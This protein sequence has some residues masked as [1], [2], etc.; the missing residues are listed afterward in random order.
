MT[1]ARENI[2]TIP[3]PETGLYPGIDYEEYNLW[4]AVR[5][6]NLF[7]LEEG[8]L[9]HYRYTVD[10]P[11]EFDTEAYRVG[12]AGHVA[13]LEP[14][15]FEERYILKPATYTTAKGETKPFNAGA[16]ICK[17]V[18]KDLAATGKSILPQDEWDLA[19]A[20]GEACR[21]KESVKY[22]LD[23]GQTEVCVVWT[24]ERTGLKCKC[25][26]DLL[27]GVNIA[28]LKTTATPA[29][30]R[31]FGSAAAKYGYPTQMQFYQAGLRQAAEVEIPLPSIIAVEKAWVQRIGPAAVQLFECRAE[32]IEVARCQNDFF[33]DR[34]KKAAESGEWSGYPDGEVTDLVLP[35][36]YGQT[37]NPA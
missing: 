1:K 24:D 36:W 5:H 2:K 15:K 4:D 32:D 31:R 9:A 10:H 30:V 12:H 14:D 37:L 26:I 11:E 28:D 20:I 3:A 29:S 27:S 35:G 8:T 16:K 13:F 7:L 18:L 21:A 6:S 23:H 25:R 22:L 33:M 34:I 19:I 17:Q